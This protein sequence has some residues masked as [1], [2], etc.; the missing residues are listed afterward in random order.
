METKLTLRLNDNVIKRAKNYA[1]SH[2]I[3]LSK[4]IESYLDSITKQKE[5]EKKIPIT[6][7]VESLSGVINLPADFDYK[8][9]YRVF[10]EEKYK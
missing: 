3:S 6:P 8:K 5:E 9:E 2:R 10:L 1:R 7:L 4:M